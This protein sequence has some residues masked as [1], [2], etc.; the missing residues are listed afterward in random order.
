MQPVTVDKAVVLTLLMVGMVGGGGVRCQTV[1][2]EGVCTTTTILGMLTTL[3]SYRCC[4]GV[5]RL[6]AMQTGPSDERLPGTEL[7]VCRQPGESEAKRALSP[8]RRDGS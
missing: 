6:P 5:R 2:V 4:S 3:A 1:G 7:E 8:C